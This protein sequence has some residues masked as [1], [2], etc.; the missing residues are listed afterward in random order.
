MLQSFSQDCVKRIPV[1]V[2]GSGASVPHGIPGMWPLGQHLAGC[3][4]PLSC[5]TDADV[6]GWEAFLEKLQHTD[7]E[8]ALTDVPITE[9]VTQH[10][11]DS[12]WTF[13][14]K[15]DLDV[16]YGV[17]ANRQLLPLTRLYQHLFRSTATDIHVVTPNYDR[18]AEYAAEAGNFCAYT[19]FNFGNIGQ[20][21]QSQAPKIFAAHRRI[22]T[23]NVWK[24]HG[25]F[26]WFRDK[27]GVVVALPPTHRLPP[28]MSP[29]IVTPGTEK[30]RRTHDEPFRSTMQN[31]DDA[32]RRANAFLCIGYG[33]NDIHLQPL[34]I[35]RCN[36]EDIPL[37]LITKGISPKAHEFF[38]SGKCRRY[39][40]IEELER[41]IRY[42]SNE[43]PDGQE[44]DGEPYWQLEHFLSLVS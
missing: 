26:G 28:G 23:V 19:G 20:R 14:N 21:A 16:F 34:L 39:L 44:L 3:P 17:V 41:G 27:D 33:F 12:T 36:A 13:L 24:V 31:A 1:V 22:R 37:V 18:L 32:M 40:A 6:Q 35:E 25:S 42:F 43:A 10:I 2:L 30:Y 38:R 9:S 15:A 4:L 29:V 8:S 5:G 7:L 11:V